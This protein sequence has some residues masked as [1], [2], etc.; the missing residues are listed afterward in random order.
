MEPAG[1]AKAKCL[2]PLVG[3]EA[4]LDNFPKWFQDKWQKSHV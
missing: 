3:H 1:A 4:L 2:L